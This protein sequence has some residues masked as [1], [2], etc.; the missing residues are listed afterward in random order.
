V[1]NRFVAT[2]GAGAL[3]IG[4]LVGAAGVIVVR[5]AV[6]SERTP[7]FGSM[8]Q[9]M[10]MMGGSMMG[11]DWPEVADMHRLHHGTGR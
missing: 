5:D 6:S 9:M 10:N 2:I 11:G 1:R 7:T 3:V 8:D 4:I